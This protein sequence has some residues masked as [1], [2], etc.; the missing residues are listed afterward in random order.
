M[1]MER[2]TPGEARGM[3]AREGTGKE[4]AK[5]GAKAELLIW[6]R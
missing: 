1:A 5:K 3:G 4:V 6:P 2:K